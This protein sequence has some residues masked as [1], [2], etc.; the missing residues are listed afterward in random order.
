MADIKND[1]NLREQA[2]FLQFGGYEDD[3]RKK[4]G[5]FGYTYD[6]CPVNTILQTGLFGILEAI[7]NL[8][9]TGR[10]I[11]D[12]YIHGH[13]EPYNDPYE[14]TRGIIK[15]I[16]GLSKDSL[17][18][19]YSDYFSD[20]RINEL[21]YK[22][23]KNT[24]MLLFFCYL[25]DDI[26][27]YIANGEDLYSKFSERYYNLYHN[28][29]NDYA[30]NYEKE[31][32]KIDGKLFRAVRFLMNNGYELMN[33]DSLFD[34]QIKEIELKQ[35]NGENLFILDKSYAREMSNSLLGLYYF[36]QRNGYNTVDSKKLFNQNCE[37]IIFTDSSGEQIVFNRC[38]LEQNVN[39]FIKTFEVLGEQKFKVA[40]T[41]I[42]DKRVE[43]I[44]L[45]Y[46]DF[47]NSKEY[48]FIV[49]RGVFP[50]IAMSHYFL[51]TI[52]EYFKQ[53]FTFQ[54]G[55]NLFDTNQEY[56]KVT[57]PNLEEQLIKRSLFEEML[58][59]IISCKKNAFSIN[60][61]QL[62]DMDS[63]SILLTDKDGNQGI[64]ERERI[65]HLM[66]TFNLLKQNGYL[67]NDYNNLFDEKKLCITVYDAQNQE[68]VLSRKQIYKIVKIQQAI[69]KNGFSSFFYY[70]K[71]LDL[72]DSEKDLLIILI[73]N[74]LK[75][76][77]F[78][79]LPYTTKKW[80]PSSAVI[81]KIPKEQSHLYF[82]NN[83]FKRLGLLKE[84]F[85]ADTYEKTEGIVSLGYILGLFDSKESV[86]KK[87]MEYIIEHF[88]NKGVTALELHKTYGAIDLSRG[89]N[90]K[91][92]DF[93][94]R[95]YALNKDAFVEDEL[96]TDM[97]SEL[98]KRFDEVLENRPE[99]KIKTRTRNKLLTPQDAISFITTFEIDE[100]LLGDKKEDERYINLMQLLMKFGASK[101]ELKWA[102]K[103]YEQALTIDEKDV[104][105]PNIVDLKGYLM[106]FNSLL[107]SDNRLF[108]SGKKTNCCSRYGGYAQDRLEHAITDV[109]WRYV[110]FTSLNKTFFDG[111]VWYDKKEK[112]VCIDNVEGQFS[113]VDKNNP[114]S[115]ALMADTIIRYADGI[116]EAMNNLKIPCQKVNVGK[117]DG[118]ASWEIFEYARNQNLIVD[119]DKPCMYPERN[120]ISTD[121]KKQ[122]TI[123]NAE[124][125]SL[126]R[127]VYGNFLK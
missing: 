119:D 100:E 30:Y 118:T 101:E 16:E 90:K 96:Q 55:E 40:I 76:K 74:N 20:S 34:E 122:F 68:R 53:G 126:K 85:H 110:T 77:L 125:L 84:K 88:L 94:M 2:F 5:T 121:A 112:V 52:I 99:K 36:L 31:F 7:I 108:L 64:I 22:R 102:I 95:H 28:H 97:T 27:E 6:C 91:F 21:Y 56:I 59:I 19:E 67:C 107:K 70:F 80:I 106:G 82:Y 13:V 4:I 58:K 98:F 69:D 120:G 29:H 35:T 38:Y 81:G 51:A 17:I 15:I 26:Y 42:F 78:Q 43:D 41:S 127:R 1:Y 44:E 9:L 103:L 63:N 18:N 111:L 39:E 57:D 14:F 8:G 32:P 10:E 12:F 86:S 92:A 50:N 89:F 60:Y 46:M 83:N 104:I 24:Q 116:Y 37:N 49:K 23:D 48:K 114:C 93:F 113:K 65:T 66:D 71:S 11:S 47:N 75:E 3:L 73:N 62:F 54:D 117:Y 87:A 123:T 45:K 72:S 124:I 79:W 61:S 25:K 115:I 105:I 109:N 33:L